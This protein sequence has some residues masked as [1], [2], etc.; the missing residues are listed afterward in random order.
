MERKAVWLER[1]LA[2]TRGHILRLLRRREQT[3]TELAAELSLT[4]NAV[5][6]HLSALERD[7]LVEALPAQPRGVGKPPVVYR[8]TAGADELRPKGYAPVLGALLGA[9]AARLPEQERDA[10]LHD[11]GR[12]AAGGVAGG[13]LRERVDAAVRVLGA[14]G[15]EGE[16]ERNGHLTIT[17]YSCPLAA[18]VSGHPEVCRLAESLVSGIV[19]VPVV[20]EC[21]RT[22]RPHCRFRVLEEER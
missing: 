13:D 22:G 3:V 16:V 18:V 10:L 20:E 12:M 5:R 11:A 15:G 17:G 2:G 6:T 14:L 7:G 9:M 19:G 8:A 21:E 4:D 1:L